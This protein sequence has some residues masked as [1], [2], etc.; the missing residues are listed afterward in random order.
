MS[1]P[2]VTPEHVAA[3][4]ALTRDA[5]QVLPAGGLAA[6]LAEGRPLRVK[7]G[8]D[9]SGTSLSIGHAVVLRMLRRFQDA[10]HTAVLIIGD[11]T[12][13]VGDPTGRSAV[14]TVLS[15][16]ETT[17]NA[18]DYL[19]QVLSLLRADRLEVRRNSEWLA[20]MT[21]PDVL[22]EARELT[23]A[24][25]LERDDFADRHAAG[26]PIS[27]VEF[28]YPLLQGYDSVAVE[29]DVELGGTDQTFNLL[30]GRDL[31]RAHGQAEQAVVTTPLLVGLDGELKMSKSLHNFV[32][33]DDP[34]EQ[35][36]GRLMSLSSDARVGEY[37]RL[38]TDL[39]PA[40]LER[41]DAAARAGGPGAAAAKREMARGIVTVYHGAAAAT[42]AEA[43]FDT[44]FRARAVPGEIAEV[45]LPPED[46]VHLPGLLRDLG[47]AASSS[48][49]R[50]L[51]TEGSVRVDDVPTR[52]FD[53]PRAALVG[54]VLR[55]GRRHQ[56]RLVSPRA[57][58]AP[59]DP[60]TAG[61]RST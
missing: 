58:E 55:V 49:G 10:G 13:T 38:C 33:L 7:F 27:L 22:R 50:R 30:V 48:A 40:D 57:E 26:T 54:A 39:P 20:A 6:K 16:A 46:P 47:W 44:I 32:A 12:G 53:A 34:P 23:V 25:L 51:V 60:P 35:M 29:A 2:A 41:I 52:H 45:A 21:F 17:A 11:I 61:T 14:R 43:A 37:A 56:A 18:S 3:A 1:P 36:F 31:Q 4:A 59:S 19:A 24:R 8:I 9:P 28:L 42:A 15:V 5:A